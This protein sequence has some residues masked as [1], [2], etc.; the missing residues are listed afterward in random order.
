MRSSLGRLANAL[1][2]S[3]AAASAPAAA[4]RDGGREPTARAFA[5]KSDAIFITANG[6]RVITRPLDR[7]DTVF[8]GRRERRFRSKPVFNVHDDSAHL[9]G[10][11]S[12]QMVGMLKIPENPTAGVEVDDDR[13]LHVWLRLIGSNSERSIR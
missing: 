6:L 12:T 13:L 4:A 9:V 1:R 10:H 5:S 2:Q 8:E 11:A 3:G 7:S